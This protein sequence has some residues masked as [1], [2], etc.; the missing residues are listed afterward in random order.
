LSLEELLA[1]IFFQ[2]IRVFFFFCSNQFLKTLL[3]F[4]KLCL[5]NLLLNLFPLS[6]SHI[7]CNSTCRSNINF[8]RPRINDD[9]SVFLTSSFNILS[10]IYDL[11]SLSHDECCI[12]I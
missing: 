8:L 5:F 10:V 2:R 12:C 6:G 7:F 11:S 3:L 4:S 9:L 1:D